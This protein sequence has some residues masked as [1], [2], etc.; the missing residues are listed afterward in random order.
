VWL[1][2][3]ADQPFVDFSAR[4]D[5]AAFL[6]AIRSNRR[7]LIDYGQRLQDVAKEKYTI[8]HMAHQH[9]RAFCDVTA[10]I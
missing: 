10:P 9:Y 3:E 6:N 5:V 8:E 2:N 4:P 1:A 7:L